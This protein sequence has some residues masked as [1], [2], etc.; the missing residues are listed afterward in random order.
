MRRFTTVSLGVATKYGLDARSAADDITNHRGPW[1]DAVL[2]RDAEGR[3][4]QTREIIFGSLGGA[5]AIAS[6][7][8]AETEMKS[9]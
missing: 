3:S 2:A 4:A 6:G 1:T 5:A 8:L 9:D 7:V